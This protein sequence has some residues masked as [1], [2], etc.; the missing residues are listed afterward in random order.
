MDGEGEGAGFG[1]CADIEVASSLFVR[2]KEKFLSKRII[3]IAK[4]SRRKR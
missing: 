3:I 1:G 2:E 4:T